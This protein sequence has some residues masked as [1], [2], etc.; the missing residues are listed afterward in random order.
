MNK[1]KIC[2]WLEFE[3]MGGCFLPAHMRGAQHGGLLAESTPH[4]KT[5]SHR[6]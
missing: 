5:D 6:R 1:W 2:R 3:V 4:K